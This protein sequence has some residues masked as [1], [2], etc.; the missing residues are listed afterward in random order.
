METPANRPS[1]SNNP[2]TI[3]FK[4]LSKS[5]LAIAS[6]LKIKWRETLKQQFFTLLY[7][8]FEWE[9]LPPYVP[10]TFIEKELIE[11]G[12][13]LLYEDDNEF[14]QFSGGV[15]S[16]GINMYDEPIIFDSITKGTNPKTQSFN[17]MT[18][19]AVLM[20]N[21]SLKQSDMLT[22]NSYLDS[23]VELK[24][25]M[26][27]NQ[28]THRTPIIMHTTKETKDQVR[29][30]AMLMDAGLPILFIDLD[31]DSRKTPQAQVMN[32]QMTLHHLHEY[33]QK[34]KDEFLVSQ[35]FNKNPYMKKERNI[36]AEVHMN[37]QEVGSALKTHL[38][39]RKRAIELAKEKGIKGAEKLNVK[40]ANNGTLINSSVNDDTDNSDNDTEP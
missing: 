11:K 24:I 17:L 20:Y 4:S 8:R 23:L 29:E 36:E 28:K 10:P 6:H 3:K 32:S 33:Y 39:Q 34:V 9:G 7:S 25:T 22:I 2:Y 31:D 16:G 27:I 19:K 38:E 26:E 5:D 18:D 14:L 15:N 40:V 1:N 30:E 35:G 21:N 37:D 12:Q 13:V